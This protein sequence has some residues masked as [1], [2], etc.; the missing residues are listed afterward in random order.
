MAARQLRFLGDERPGGTCDGPR[1]SVDALR[2]ARRREPGR[3]ECSGAGGRRAELAQL[4]ISLEELTERHLGAVEALLGDSESLRFTRV[5]EPVPPGFARAWLERNEEGRA[6]GSCEAFAVL[7]DGSAFLGMALAPRID[8]ATATAELGYFVAP[9]ARGRGVATEALRQLTAWAFEK[10]GMLRVELLIGVD[11]TASKKVAARC[12]YVLEGV[13][14]SA[15]FKQD[16]REDTEI[17]SRLSTD[18]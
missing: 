11:N 15:Y 18:P 7:E 13:L 17:W 3:C 6:D 5:P 10:Q 14:R 1:T 8:R 12:G 9:E 2:A 4:T 16:L